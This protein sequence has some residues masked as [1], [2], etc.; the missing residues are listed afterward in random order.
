LAIEQEVDETHAHR[1]PGGLAAI[2]EFLNARL[3]PDR[4]TLNLRTVAREIVWKS[5]R[6]E[7]RVVSPEGYPR[8]TI[9]ARRLLLTVPLGVLQASPADEIMRSMSSV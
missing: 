8:P 5:G 6:A 9:T 1:L 3:N 7:I 4:A 2:P